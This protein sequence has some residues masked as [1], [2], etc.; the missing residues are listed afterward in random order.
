MLLSHRHSRMK[1]KMC[2]MCLCIWL[3]DKFLVC[4]WCTERH[5]TLYFGIICRRYLIFLLGQREGDKTFNWKRVA[6]GIGKAIIQ[7]SIK[8]F[9]FHERK[10]SFVFRMTNLCCFS[11][12]YKSQ[13]LALLQQGNVSITRL[14]M[15]TWA[16]SKPLLTPADLPVI[17]FLG[18]VE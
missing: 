4:N 13:M 9:K 15:L 18:T 14:N 12:G 11:N 10:V 8:I 16:F 3:L 17:H 1:H 2:K 7:K 6:K 5:L